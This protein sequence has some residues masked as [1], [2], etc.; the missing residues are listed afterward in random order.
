MLA[1]KILSFLV[2]LVAVAQ[3]YINKIDFVNHSLVLLWFFDIHRMFKFFI[4]IV[5]VTIKHWYLRT[6]CTS[7]KKTKHG[8]KP[9]AVCVKAS[10]TWREWETLVQKRLQT[11]ASASHVGAGVTEVT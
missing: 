10:C 8:H 9:F 6:L 11:I 1:V 5:L 2:R 4:V 7:Q 3:G